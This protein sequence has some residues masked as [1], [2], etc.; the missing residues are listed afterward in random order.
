VTRL[1]ALRPVLRLHSLQ[2]KKELSSPERERGRERERERE[3][4]HANGLVF[5]VRNLDET[6]GSNEKRAMSFSPFG[7]V[8]RRGAVLRQPP[9]NR[10]ISTNQTSKKPTVDY[11]IAAWIA[12]RVQ[13]T[14]FRRSPPTCCARTACMFGCFS[15]RFLVPN[16]DRVGYSL[17]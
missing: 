7:F 17:V 16:R 10:K 4:G 6:N 12:F 3:T 14:H 2:R 15:N 8:T 13:P 1:Y 9:L 5:L 11:R